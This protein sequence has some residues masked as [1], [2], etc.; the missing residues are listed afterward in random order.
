MKQPSHSQRS[1]P[2]E[3]AP[4]HASGGPARAE[5]AMIIAVPKEVHA[6]KRRVAATPDTVGQ[7]RKLG[8]E[9]SVETGAGA[10]APTPSRAKP[11]A[12]M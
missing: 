9:V 4:Q 8:F 12:C 6:G 10:A 2:R 5:M 1:L 3:G 11:P 7:L